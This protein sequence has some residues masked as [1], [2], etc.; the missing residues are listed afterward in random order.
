MTHDMADFEWKSAILVHVNHVVR[1]WRCGPFLPKPQPA[2]K[3]IRMR[4]SLCRLVYGPEAEN[5]TQD[6]PRGPPCPTQHLWHLPEVCHWFIRRN[7]EPAM[8]H[9]PEQNHRRIMGG[10]NCT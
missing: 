2:S 3:L 4:Q 7:K 5:A 1:T 6:S 9:I 10:P 8:G